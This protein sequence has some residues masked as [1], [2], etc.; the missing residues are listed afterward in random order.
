MPA[1]MEAFLVCFPQ[2]LQL[3]ANVRPRM[4]SVYPAS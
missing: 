1:Q 3:W 2:K 4:N